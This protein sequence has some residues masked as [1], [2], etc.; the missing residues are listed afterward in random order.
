ML[1]PKTIFSRCN[2]DRPM[3][4]G[5]SRAWGWQRVRAGKAASGVEARARRELRL[6]WA[7]QE[8]SARKGRLKGE[9][10]QFWLRRV[11]N[12]GEKSL[13]I[14]RLRRPNAFLFR[15]TL[16]LRLPSDSSQ[17]ASRLLR[18]APLRSHRAQ[19]G[20]RAVRGFGG[21]GEPWRL[22]LRFQTDSLGP[23]PHIS[24]SASLANNI[25]RL[26]RPQLLLACAQASAKALLGCVARSFSLALR[27]EQAHSSSRP[28]AD[29]HSSDQSKANRLDPTG[30]SFQVWRPMRTNLDTP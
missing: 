28:A 16:G 5:S 25:P 18:P 13:G 12:G 24:L 3:P 7:C 17:L 23:P 19:H 1:S 9:W 10:K 14:V 22:G 26:A 30:P 15:P 21:A 27:L 11:A 20:G 6:R 2:A 4:V 8:A 29:A